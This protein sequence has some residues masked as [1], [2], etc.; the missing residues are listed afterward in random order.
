M[1]GIW[2]KLYSGMWTSA[3]TGLATPRSRIKLLTCN[4]RRHGS[5]KAMLMLNAER[6]TYA[7]RLRVFATTFTGLLGKTPGLTGLIP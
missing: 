3:T 1:R 7:Q 2:L 6:C 5:A 4:P